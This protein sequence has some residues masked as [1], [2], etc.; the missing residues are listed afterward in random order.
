MSDKGLIVRNVEVPIFQVVVSLSVRSVHC[1][2]KPG[3]TSEK[4]SDTKLI[5]IGSRLLACVISSHEK[6]YSANWLV[7]RNLFQYKPQS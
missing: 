7:S 5:K 1:I 6:W 3:V 4:M 2:L